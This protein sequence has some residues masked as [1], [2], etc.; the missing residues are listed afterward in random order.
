MR[1]EEFLSKFVG[2]WQKVD[3][4]ENIDESRTIIVGDRFDVERSTKWDSVKECNVVNIITVDYD[5]DY[6]YSDIERELSDSMS[7]LVIYVE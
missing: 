7:V 6:P 5:E 3:I 4:C 1:L 2:N